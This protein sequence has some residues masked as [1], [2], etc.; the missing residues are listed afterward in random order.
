ME[1]LVA[2]AIISLLTVIGVVSYSSINKRSRDAKRT[3]DLEQMRSALEM[4]RA[5]N[6]SYPAVNT[7]GFATAANLNTGNPSTGL[8][9]T[10]VPAIPKD[11][12]DP[13]V[14][15]YFRATDYNATTGKYYGYC[16]CGNLE[17]QT[18]STSTCSVALAAACNYGL[19]NP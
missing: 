3:S 2:V 10:Y 16:V 4:F 19:K 11:P 1:V 14:I 7:S 17:S 13:T 5:D 6:G 18:G 8:V 12:K 15:Y 9:S